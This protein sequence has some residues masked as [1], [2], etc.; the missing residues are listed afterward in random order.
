MKIRTILLAA[1]AI[2][3]AAVLV[4]AGGTKGASRG[5]DDDLEFA[6]SRL[7]IE[8]NA[9]D[10]DVGVQ[11]SLD[12]EPWRLLCVYDPRGRKIMTIS[13]S[14][15]LRKQGLTELFWESSEPPLEDLPL[16]VFFKRFPAGEYEFEGITIDGEEIEG[17]AIF[18][19]IIPDPVEILWPASDVLQNPNDID[20][21]WNA[22]ADPPGSAIVA[23]QVVVTHI[24]SGRSFSVHVPAG[25][26]SVSVPPEFMQ[27][28]ADYEFEVLAIEAGGNQTIASSEFSTME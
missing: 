26:T 18:T 5:G 6:R 3:L 17:S 25:V 13:N 4:G 14:G 7:Y 28:G 19:H 24:E 27:F 2:P 21:F 11:V 20:V 10:E 15:S 8:Y 23:Y 22:P 9:T 12:G 16:D 1:I